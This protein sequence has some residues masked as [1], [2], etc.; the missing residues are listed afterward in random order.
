MQLFR[1]EALQGQDRLH[2]DVVLVPPVSWRLLG[3]FLAATVIAAAIFLAIARFDQMT[4]V[5]GRIV[6]DRPI[7][8]IVA[9]EDG[10]VEAMLVADGARVAAG[11]P[12]FRL[13]STTVTAAQGGTVTGILV[14]SGDAAARNQP[15]LSIVPVGTLLRARIEIPSAAARLAERGQ[16]VAL[17]FDGAGR[18]RG[19]AI[20]RIESVTVAPGGRTAS[21]LASLDPAA[22]P[23]VRTR[24]GAIVRARIPTGSRSLAD[25]LL[26]S[27]A[28]RDGR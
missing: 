8:P 20:G 10:V 11:T 6:A 9:P 22:G 21:L 14:G 2:G 28:G 27:V 15:I 19:N 17:E 18:D 16:A 12:L 23:P 3:I 25:W 4:L 26:Q 5:T 1:P 13:S 24:P 7:A